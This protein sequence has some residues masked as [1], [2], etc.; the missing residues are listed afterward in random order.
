M[1]VAAEDLR[2]IPYFATLPPAALAGLAARVRVREWA[3]G[4]L[5]FLEGE[6]CQGLYYLQAGR[7]RIFKA[8]PTGREQ[9]LMVIGPGETF[10]D[11]PV[12]DGGP[13]PATA[14]ATE[15]SRVLLVP[16]D[17]LVA[18]VQEQPAAALAIIGRLAGR[19]RQLTLLVE[20]LSLR[21]V[22]GRLARLLLRDAE[23]GEAERLTQQEMAARVGT[24]REV[25][26][27]AL[28]ALEESGAI[29]V[30]QGRVQVRDRAALERQA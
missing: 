4:A 1:S 19:L 3:R 10:N 12:F 25:L 26:G 13:N 16:R 8:S 24:A 28:R 5:L 14:Q 6:P 7:V 15:P 11:V 29:E 30:R 20:D 23:A 2:A 27:R 17:D 21:H 22:T 18:L 9:V